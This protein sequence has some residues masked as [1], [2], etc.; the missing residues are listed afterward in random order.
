MNI[1]KRPL[2]RTFDCVEIRHSDSL[3]SG[4]IRNIFNRT[5]SD[6]P[7]L[8][9]RWPESRNS[10]F[11]VFGPLSIFPDFEGLDSLSLLRP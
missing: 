6:K 11:T 8:A 9:L 10:Q 7:P 4:I 5:K 3:K 2:A 1:V